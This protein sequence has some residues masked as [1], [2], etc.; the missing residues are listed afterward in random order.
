MISSRLW[1]PLALACMLSA[2]AGA[3]TA[4]AQTVVIRGLVPGAAAELVQ[5]GA[6]PVTGAANDAG[7]AILK[8]ALRDATDVRVN[9]YVDVCANVR[10]VLIV[11]RDALPPALQAGCDRTPI[12]GVFVIRDISSVV[13]SLGGTQPTLLLRQGAYDLRPQHEWES[14]VPDG[15]IVFG[16]AGFGKLHNAKGLACGSLNDCPGD[17]TG[18]A[19]T[20]GIAYWLTPNIGVEAS[21]LKPAKVSTTGEIGTATFT[22]T[23]NT[24]VLMLVA[25]V[26]APVG[27]VRL[28]AQGGGTYHRATI[29]SVQTWLDVE[30]RFELSTTGWG[31][32]FGGGLETWVAPAVAFYLEAGRGA[33]KGKG[34]ETGG[35]GRFDERVSYAIAGLKVSIKR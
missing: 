3:A 32:T 18:V 31:W 20:G 7:D 13:I 6:P 22:D 26:G 24:H 19:F 27:R 25:K 16:G 9:F 2:T 17:D 11:G 8:G 5:D 1:R 21:Y 15:L 4:G 35:E 14:I 34:S 29:G 12:A 30:D 23:V 33:L 10:R 28:Y